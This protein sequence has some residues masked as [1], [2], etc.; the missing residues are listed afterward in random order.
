VLVPVG[1]RETRE[2][3]AVS[4]LAIAAFIF[5][6]MVALA[7]TAPI[8]GYDSRDGVESDQSARR[9]SWLHDRPTAR[10]TRSTSVPVAGALRTVAHR[11]DARSAAPAL[12]DVTDPRLAEAC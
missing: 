9:I 5:A 8:W 3:I 10:A 7:I 6:C 12:A 2:S 1:A 4:D 11:I